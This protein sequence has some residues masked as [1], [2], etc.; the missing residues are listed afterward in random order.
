MVNIAAAIVRRGKAYL[1]VS[2]QTDMGVYVDYEPVFTANL[3]VDELTAAFEQ[4]VAEGHPRIPHPTQEEWR[5]WKSPVL[6]A[7]GVQSWKQMAQGG[8]SYSIEW[9]GDKVTL[10]ISHPKDPHRWRDAPVE[11]RVFPRDTPLRTIVE[12]ILEDVRSR[13]ELWAGDNEIG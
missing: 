13:P 8:A 2:A 7:A 5:R 10:Y 9:G 11:T 1:P 3:T 12:T 6:A 4:V